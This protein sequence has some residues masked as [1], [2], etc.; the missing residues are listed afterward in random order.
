[1]DAVVSGDQEVTRLLIEGGGLSDAAEFE[2]RFLG[3]STGDDANDAHR[4]EVAAQGSN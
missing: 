2:G 1:M 3:P 4:V